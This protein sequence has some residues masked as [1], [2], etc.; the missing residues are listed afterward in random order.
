MESLYWNSPQIFIL[1]YEMVNVCLVY[2]WTEM[3]VLNIYTVCII[4]E[5]QKKQTWS[6]HNSHHPKQNDN[7]RYMLIV[8]V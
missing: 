1:G 3:V 7:L 2:P 4:V 8:H 5:G 6:L